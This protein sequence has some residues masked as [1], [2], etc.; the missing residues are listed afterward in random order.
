MADNLKPHKVH[1]DLK[2]SAGSNVSQFDVVIAE[3]GD[4]DTR[5]PGQHKKNEI[6][7][8]KDIDRFVKVIQGALSTVSVPQ[9][10]TI[11]PTLG[12][13]AWTA[14]DPAQMTNTNNRNIKQQEYNNLGAE[15]VTRGVGGMSTHWFQGTQRPVL[16]EDSK[17]DNDEWDVLY[18]AAESLIGTS[19]TEFDRSIR[20]NVVLNAL[21]TA[22]SLAGREAAPLPLACHRLAEG[23]PYVQWHAADNIYGDL[24][25]NKEKKNK[26]G[27]KRG[28]FALLT[29]TRVTKYHLHTESTDGHQVIGLVEVMDLLEDRLSPVEA[30]TVNFSINAKVYVTAA[31][32]VA[33]PQILANS[34]FGGM[35]ESEE[36]RVK[37]PIP[38][39]VKDIDN[40]DGKPEWWVKAVKD[41]KSD[42]PNDPLPIYGEV[43]PKVD[44][45]LVVDLRFFGRQKGSP[46]NRLV[47]E[48]FTDA[49]GMP[50]P[51]FE[52]IPTSEGAGESQA[53]M[54]D[55]TNVANELG[56]YLPGSEPQFM[57]IGSPSG[58]DNSGDIKT[59]VANFNSQ[60]WNFTNLFV[61][62]NGTIPTGFGANPT[63][64]SM[65]L[66]FRSVYKIHKLLESGGDFP[67]AKADDPLDVTPP[68]FLSWTQ[69]PN[70]PNFPNHH[71]LRQLHKSV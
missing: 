56:A 58:R 27:Q 52:Y 41:H 16:F 59:T 33:T 21:R 13:A 53:M 2:E 51:T 29:N 15:A 60:V 54:N 50:Q 67:A 20:H 22:R 7:Y 57:T 32:A 3:I 55:M 10:A 6:E 47:F 31:G 68:E 30:G 45:R 61:A 19:T 42:H 23:S 5:V 69:D 17:K 48:N 70:D 14:D 12:P 25:D 40:F 34:G 4:Q 38:V 37:R 1:D 71:L 28:F 66:A 65:C 39:L 43:G 44:P 49:Y 63:L 35:R 8:Q 36:G 9:S 46:E 24:F 11:V 26:A 18:K 62:G 64:T